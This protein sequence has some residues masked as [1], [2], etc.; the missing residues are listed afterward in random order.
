VSS[1]WLAASA[2]V[3][4]AAMSSACS[5]RGDAPN[6]PLAFCKAAAEYDHRL[7]TKTDV[8][9]RV[10]IRMVSDIVETAPR[11][12]VADARTFLDALKTARTDPES[13]RD[14]PEIRR[15][16]ENVN[17]YAAQGCDFYARRGGGI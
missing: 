3:A 13:V 2:L 8:P 15:A 4:A 14:K 5:G 12:V 9:L 17:R 16:V 6:A 7:S 1:R 10:Q 11:K